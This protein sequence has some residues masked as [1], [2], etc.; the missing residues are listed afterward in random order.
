MGVAFAVERCQN[1]R[2]T[3]C[4]VVIGRGSDAPAYCELSWPLALRILPKLAERYG[5][6]ADDHAGLFAGRVFFRRDLWHRAA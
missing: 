1:E 6:P 2:E 4:R 3:W 5:Y